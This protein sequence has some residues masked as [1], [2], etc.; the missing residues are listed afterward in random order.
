M[1]RLVGS[2]L[3]GVSVSALA[4][5]PDFSLLTTPPPHVFVGKPA[6]YSLS[7][8]P[9]P[10]WRLLQEGPVEIR[11]SGENV[12]LVRTALHHT[13]AVDPHAEVPRFE[14][15]AVSK[16]AG[17]ATLEARCVFYLC[18]KSRCRPVEATAQFKLVVS[19]GDVPV[20]PRRSIAPTSLPPP[21]ANRASL[22]RGFNRG[23]RENQGTSL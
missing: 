12:R 1:W 21:R 11:L 16:T 4:D 6:T 3:L 19:G 13:D 9:R 18:D 15:T 22:T 17:P 2:L 8:A 7:I 23:S 20:P 10:G 5:E 14:W